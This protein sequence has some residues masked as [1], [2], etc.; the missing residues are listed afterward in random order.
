MYNTVHVHS[1]TVGSHGDHSQY[2]YCYVP[3]HILMESTCILSVSMI[4]V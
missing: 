3:S 1:V 2:S 4:L